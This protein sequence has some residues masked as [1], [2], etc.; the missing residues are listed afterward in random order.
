MSKNGAA[1]LNQCPQAEPKARTTVMDDFP[2]VVHE[3]SPSIVYMFFSRSQH[4]LSPQHTQSAGRTMSPTV[5]RSSPAGGGPAAPEHATPLSPSSPAH[6]DSPRLDAPS[7]AH[8]SS[9]AATTVGAA[10]MCIYKGGNF[11]KVV[12]CNS[13]HGHRPQESPPW[14]PR[15]RGIGCRP[16]PIPPSK[17]ILCLPFLTWFGL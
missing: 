17:L 12:D 16:L 8:G 11:E 5:V 13:P 6:K 14:H 7:H 4:S 1:G 15:P 3:G 2:R 10:A 9:N